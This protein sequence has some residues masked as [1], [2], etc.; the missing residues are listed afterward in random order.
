MEFLNNV[1]L[2]LFIGMAVYL[3]IGFIKT[4]KEV[5]IKAPKFSKSILI[6]FALLTFMNIMTLLIYNSVLDIIRTVLITY[7]IIVMFLLKDGLGEN[8]VVANSTYI[9]YDLIEAYDFEKI[10][11]GFKVYI[12]YRSVNERKDSKPINEVS[13]IFDASQEK[14]V[15]DKLQ[16]KL[17]KKYRRMK[18]S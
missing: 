10:K 8:G 5:T 6:I 4:R 13:I 7:V 16:Q 18:K 11:K 9:N 3:T 14:M 2:L 15:K 12:G 17:P 1:L